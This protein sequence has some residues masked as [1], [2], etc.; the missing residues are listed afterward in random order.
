MGEKTTAH[1]LEKKEIII[2]IQY[3]YKP[4]K[5]TSRLQE[6]MKKHFKVTEL[7]W[8]YEKINVFASH[9]YRSIDQR[10]DL[11]GLLWNLFSSLP[12]GKCSRP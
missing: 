11:I 4:L 10:V 8:T 9:C 3:K 6:G 7:I 1:H 12:N 2:V 5:A